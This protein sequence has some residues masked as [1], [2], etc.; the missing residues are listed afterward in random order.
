M[1]LKI[2]DNYKLVVRAFGSNKARVL[3]ATFKL[4]KEIGELEDRTEEF[5][6][7]GASQGLIKLYK[8]QD[9]QQFKLETL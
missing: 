5:I 7:G 6:Q 9:E 3:A 1:Q 4:V 2:P 8:Q